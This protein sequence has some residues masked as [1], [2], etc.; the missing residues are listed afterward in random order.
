MHFILFYDYVP[1][2][3]EKRAPHRSNHLKLI[4]AAFDANDLVLAGALVEPLDGAALV[5]RS[6]EAAEHFAQADPYV[7]G[8]VAKS[9]R[10]RKWQTVIGDGAAMPPL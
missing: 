8:G 10:V 6:A 2:A 1:D 3:L 9:W 5:F 7:T 4:Q